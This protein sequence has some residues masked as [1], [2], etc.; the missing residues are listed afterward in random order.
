[1]NEIHDNY[2]HKL[3]KEQKEWFDTA[4]TGLVYCHKCDIIKSWEGEVNCKGDFDWKENVNCHPYEVLC[5]SCYDEN[6]RTIKA[7]LTIAYYKI[8]DFIREVMY[9]HTY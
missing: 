7:R 9:E 2:Y 5:H 3:T 1:M 6:S 8:V 4:D